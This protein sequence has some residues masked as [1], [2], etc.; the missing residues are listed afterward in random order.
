[1]HT[2]KARTGRWRDVAAAALVTTAIAGGAHAGPTRSTAPTTWLYGAD[3]TSALFVVD[4]ASGAARRIGD[5]GVRGMTDI[6]FTPNGRLYGV[7]FTQLYRSS[8]ERAARSPSAEAS[9]WEASTRSPPIRMA[10][11]T[12]PRRAATSAW[13]RSAP[14]VRRS[15]A[16]TERGSAPPAISRSPGTERCT[17]RHSPPA[18]SV[19][20]RVDPATG[21]AS[22]R[23]RLA[24]PGRLRSCVRPQR[25]PRRR[26]TRKR[27][28]GRPRLDR[29]A[30]RDGRSGS[31]RSRA[32]RGC[33]G[34][35][36]GR[37]PPRPLLPV[38]RP[39]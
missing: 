19:L 14:G 15:S 26:R 25:E 18:G 8:H 27:D 35:R 39:R 36:R 2:T 13:S 3:A 7:T 10:A 33:G 30:G 1:M 9:A 32:P 31:A 6:A 28:P 34:S 29:P 12:S 38:P 22:I 16:R 17:R 20:L 11:S 5:T 24:L 23:A 37:T 21:L 4:A